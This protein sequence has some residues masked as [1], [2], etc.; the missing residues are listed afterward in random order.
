MSL[1]NQNFQLRCGKCCKKATPNTPKQEWENII[2]VGV[3]GSGY[4]CICGNCGHQS[5]RY[6]RAAY[7]RYKAQNPT[8]KIGD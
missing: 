2:V 5:L 4:K 1:S 8:V 3:R 6:S 7:R